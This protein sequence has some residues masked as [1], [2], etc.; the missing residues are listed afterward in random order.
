MRKFLFVLLSWAA[1]AYAAK[2]R[3]QLKSFGPLEESSAEV[4]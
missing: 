2:I 4:K 1:V 3:D